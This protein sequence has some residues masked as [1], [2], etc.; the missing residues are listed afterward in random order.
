MFP[1]MF[2]VFCWSAPLGLVVYWTTNNIVQIGQQY[3]LKIMLPPPP[4]DET[5]GSGKK[6]KSKRKGSGSKDK[7]SGS[8]ES[9]ARSKRRKG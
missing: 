1:I 5:S 9:P 3:L 7:S 2:V 4:T 8:S 6:T